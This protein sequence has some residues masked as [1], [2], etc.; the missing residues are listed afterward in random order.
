MGALNVPLNGSGREAFG[1]GSR[2]DMENSD[3]GVVPT[4]P[5]GLDGV[6]GEE[7]VAICVSNNT[8]PCFPLQEMKL[9]EAPLVCL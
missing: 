9:E 4:R 8:A 7:E 2:A 6:W 3:Q 5:G 1:Q